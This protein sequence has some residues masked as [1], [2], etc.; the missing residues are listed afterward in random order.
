[1]SLFNALARNESILKF[2]CPRCSREFQTHQ[3][4]AGQRVSCPACHSIF[5]VPSNSIDII[6]PIGDSIFDNAQMNELYL[7]FLEQHEDRVKSQRTLESIKGGNTLLLEVETDTIRTQLVII[8]VFETD[9]DSFAYIH[10]NVG[11]IYDED[12]Y[13]HALRASHETFNLFSL[14]LD[15]NH[16][17][18][19]RSIRKLKNY[20][21]EEFNLNVIGLANFADTLE[22]N[23]IGSDHH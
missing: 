11:E 6:K 12:Q 15:E 21:S 3:D 19:V 20:D 7:S 17:L 4:Q 16:M 2:E 5:R 22:E 18:I 9:I 14:S 23:L 8:S 13:F 10:S 1:M